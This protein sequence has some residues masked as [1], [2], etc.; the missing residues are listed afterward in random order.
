MNCPKC[1][2]N[3]VTERVEPLDKGGLWFHCCGFHINGDPII[4]TDP[5]PLLK[6]CR[7]SFPIPCAISGLTNGVSIAGRKLTNDLPDAFRARRK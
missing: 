2:A 5:L 3:I 1:T 4:D 7:L 6:K